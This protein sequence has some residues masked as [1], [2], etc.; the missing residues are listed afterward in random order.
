M[1]KPRIMI[2]G[3]GNVLLS[4][5]GL[6]VQF[7]NELAEEDLPENVELLEG[8]TAGLELVHLIQDTDFLIIVDA[9]NAQTT[10]GELF[11]FQPGDM[12]IFPDKFTVSFH[13]VGILNVLTT[14]NILGEVPQT[15][16]YGVQPGSLD[17][18]LELT[19][20]VKAAFPRLKKYVLNDIHEIGTRGRFSC[21]TPAF[22]DVE[23]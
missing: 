7:L 11:R 9:L 13:Q 8:G 10:P 2:L 6:G 22:P 17:W 14:A 20:E 18:G 23:Q 3:V 1:Q 21:P 5:E 15:I 12:Q 16:I 19:P 4:D